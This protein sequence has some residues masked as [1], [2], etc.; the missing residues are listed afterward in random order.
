MSI[1]RAQNSLS[2][3]LMADPEVVVCPFA[4]VLI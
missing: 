3:G 2:L 4:H 1:Q